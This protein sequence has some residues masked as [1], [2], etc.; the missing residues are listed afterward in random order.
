MG[1]ASDFLMRRAARIFVIVFWT[2]IWGRAFYV[3][4]TRFSTLGLHYQILD[5]S[6]ALLIPLVLWVYSRN[7]RGETP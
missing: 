3:V 7:L 5:S 2:L 4:A 6:F 1:E